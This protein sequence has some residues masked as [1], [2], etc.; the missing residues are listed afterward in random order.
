MLS[1]VELGL[2]TALSDGPLDRDALVKRL[3]LHGRG[4]NDFF[5]LLVALGLL[6]RDVDGRYSNAPDCALY[7][8]SRKPTYLGGL[9][10]YL[11]TRM[12]QTWSLLTQAL[13]TGKPQSGPSAA[14]GF[15]RF[16][17]DKLTAEIF[18]KGMSGGSIVAARTLATCFP[19][20]EYRTV[21][22]IGT[23]QGCVP[24]EIARVHAHLR[25]GG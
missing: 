21:I 10:E 9:F 23:A 22:D 20:Q 14:G 7:L 4:A 13:R 16:Y 8:D 2:F 1:A 12:Y 25:G 18:L 17:E 6:D 19:W 15:D 11:N 24:V 3:E 5:D